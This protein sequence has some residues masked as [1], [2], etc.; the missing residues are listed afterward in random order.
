MRPVPCKPD[1]PKRNATCHSWCP[2]YKKWRV[3]KDKENEAIYKIKKGER[4]YYGHC[5]DYANKCRKG[6]FPK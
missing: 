1:C 2:D 4:D 5:A 3:E 6:R